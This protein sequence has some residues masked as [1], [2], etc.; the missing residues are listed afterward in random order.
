[1]SIGESD[2][3]NILVHYP[4]IGKTLLLIFCGY[5]ITWYLQIGYRVPVLGIIRFEFI[6]AA[7]LTL[8][9]FFCTPRIDIKCSLLKY[10]L[11]YFLVIIMQIPFSYDIETSLNIFADRFVKFAFMTFFIV[12]FVRSPTQLKYFIGAFLLACL[13]MGEEG[14]VGIITGGLIWENQGIIRLHGSTPIYEHPNSFAGMALGTLPFVYYLL[15]LSDKYIKLMLMLV[16]FFSMVVIIYTGSRTGYVGIITFLLYII[17]KSD[18]KI[19]CMIGILIVTIS[20]M[21]IVPN[22]YVERLSSIYT[23]NDKEGRSI[24]V[25]KEIIKDAWHI[26]LDHPL[27]VGLGAFPKIRMEKYGR[28]QDTHNLYLEIATNI[29]IQG[30]V[31]FTL[32]IYS[33]INTLKKIAN[34]ANNKLVIYDKCNYVVNI[35]LKYVEA[36]A[37]ATIGFI[38]VRLSLGLFG[39]DLY[40]I[41]WWFAIGITLS[42]YSIMKSIAI[43]IGDDLNEKHF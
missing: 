19:K 32:L 27:G 6:Y 25:R 41:Y 21:L 30:L 38:I 3:R 18:K 23:Q 22:D 42:L 2:P 10:I 16:C 1:M 43:H 12:A 11:I 9:A 31:A 8:L 40:E 15:P 36:V 29:G 17:Y 39:M 4:Y 7:I 5:V 34:Y 14:F 24:E 13:K 20:V 26:F 33:L 37:N 35:D 28:I